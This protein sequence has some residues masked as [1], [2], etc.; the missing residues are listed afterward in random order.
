MKSQSYNVL[1]RALVI[2]G[3]G[4]I[5]LAFSAMPVAAA[6]PVTVEIKVVMWGPQAEILPAGDDGNHFVGMGRRTG[7]AEFSDGRKADYSNVFFM[8][9]FRG[10]SANS[11]GY[12]KMVFTDGSWIF[13]KW[14]AEVSGRDENGAPTFAGTGKLQKG[15][16]AYEGISGGV[17]FKNKR[18]PPNEKYPQGATEA[19][20]VLTYTLPSQ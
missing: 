20:A 6:K 4:I 13:F 10:K 5:F 19:N 11:W 9:V 2:I 16:G 3:A 15:T 14:N 18:I 17:K 7:E 1:C 12:T 8:D